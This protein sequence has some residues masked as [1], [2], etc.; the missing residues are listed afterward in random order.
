LNLCWIQSCLSANLA[1][2]A[3]HHRIFGRRPSCSL[4][5]FGHESTFQIAQT[6]LPYSESPSCPRRMPLSSSLRC[7]FIPSKSL[8]ISLNLLLSTFLHSLPLS[9]GS[10]SILAIRCSSARASQPCS[11][12]LNAIPSLASL[13]PSQVRRD[14]LGELQDLGGLDEYRASVDEKLRA[15]L[16]K[17]FQVHLPDLNMP[18][19]KS[20]FFSTLHRREFPRAFSIRCVRPPEPQ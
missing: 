20:C 10:G 9:P 4:A 2:L 17:Q 3:A 12:L 5:M 8:S 1:H 11:L 15:S 14:L 16:I 7:V 6:T 18:I 13:R 19:T